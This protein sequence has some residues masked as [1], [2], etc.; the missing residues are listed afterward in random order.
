VDEIREEEPMLPGLADPT[1]TQ[2]VA[3]LT[4]DLKEANVDLDG[5][6]EEIEALFDEADEEGNLEAM[7]LLW[8][9]M[10]AVRNEKESEEPVSEDAEPEV[11]AESDEDA[12]PE[13]E[14]EEEQNDETTTPD[15]GTAEMSEDILTSG[16]VPADAVPIAAAGALDTVPM[17][18]FRVG[19]DV[20]GFTA[21]AALEHGMDDV[22][23]A[24]TR[25]VNSLRGVGGDGDHSLVASVRYETEIPDE[26]LL[27]EGDS[28]GNSRKV[29]QLLSD[30]DGL[31]AAA[32]T[33]AGWCA[34]T[35]VIYDVS[36]MAIGTTARPVRDSLPSFTAERGSISWTEPPSI[37]Q[38]VSG[39]TLFKAD[40]TTFTDPQG[41]VATN[42]TSTKQ[43]IDIT[44]GTTE[45]AILDALS[46]CLCFDNLMSR[47]YPEWVRA[48]TDLSMVAQ[49]A[50]AEKYLLYRMFSAAPAAGNTAGS[51][52]GTP[53]TALGAARDFLVMVRLV[54]TQL[55]WRN[56]LSPTHPLQILL[57]TWLRDAMVSDMMIQM[58]GDNTMGTSREE[59]VG[60]LNAIN[61]DPIWYIDDVPA[62]AGFPI[63]STD[64]FDSYLGYAADANWLLYPTGTFL[65][66]DAGSLDLGIVRTKED[67]Q[68][69]KYCSF[70]E[71]FE[72]IAYMGPADKSVLVGGRTA[73]S[74]RGG[75]APTVAAIDTA[76]GTV[77]E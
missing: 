6:I 48:N 63:A 18:T 32:L 68:K 47:A 22:V 1:F 7:R 65:R 57:P 34:P 5:L 69:N 28:E 42:P 33:A 15:E 59:V 55:R 36:S 25:K 61:V 21:G 39:V 19:G 70:A 50:F 53:D 2:R 60:Y 64:N 72:G 49:A 41:T 35:Q 31:T 45:T 23:E 37:S 66:L 26:R 16:D 74:I 52:I 58:P 56:R 71:T 29:R 20:P 4:A 77:G 24:M 17:P 75:Y 9:L 44:C 62:V 67:I 38:A 73:I 14:V 10:E 13:A 12:E 8:G 46:V 51:I 54:A 40:G 76:G 3:E 11:E 27:R 30:P 43:C